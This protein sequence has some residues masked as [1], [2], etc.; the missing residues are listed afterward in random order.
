MWFGFGLG[1]T[2]LCRHR[3]KTSE[4]IIA[5]KK[6]G[7]QKKGARSQGAGAGARNGMLRVDPPLALRK[8]T[9]RGCAKQLR[10]EANVRESRRRGREPGVGGR[11]RNVASFPSPIV[12][13]AIKVR[14]QR[15]G[16]ESGLR[17]EVKG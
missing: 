10:C 4:G 13:E 7:G 16:V 3:L 15:E 6:E 1:E 5:Q 17:K 2:G 8:V 12:R 14:S 11:G 9:H